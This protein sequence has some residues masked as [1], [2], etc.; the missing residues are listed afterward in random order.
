MLIRNFKG[1]MKVSVEK[2]S[3]NFYSYLPNDV[4]VTFLWILTITLLFLCFTVFVLFCQAFNAP[5]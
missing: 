2:P 1:T 4:L 5:R 3:I